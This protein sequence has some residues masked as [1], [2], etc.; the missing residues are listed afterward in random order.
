MCLIILNTNGGNILTR[1]ER[2]RYADDNPHG[3][4][5]AIA[6]NGKLE[7]EKDVRYGSFPETLPNEPWMLHFRFATHGE[8]TIE[9]CHP[10][11]LT[12]Q[13]CIA[14]N[15]VLSPFMWDRTK[16]D[17]WH[18]VETLKEWMRKTGFGP[19]DV[20]FQEAIN[21]SIASDR[22]ATFNADGGAIYYGNWHHDKQ[23]DILFSRNPASL[24]FKPWDNLQKE[25]VN[26]SGFLAQALADEKP[27]P[28][29]EA[30]LDTQTDDLDFPDDLQSELLDSGFYSF[31]DVTRM[32]GWEQEQAYI[33]LL[34]QGLILGKEAN[35][36]SS[37]L[38]EK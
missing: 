5:L 16:S 30:L 21:M 19:N 29:I 7:Y 2:Q 20:P 32:A 35:N 33:E 4:G 26:V 27:K 36:V 18:F 37:N 13:T 17:T 11:A 8:N 3:Y 14:H 15:G 38:S 9:N 31:S 28:A 1:T 22:I 12:E 23:R 25:R 24:N 6:R 34:D 10:F